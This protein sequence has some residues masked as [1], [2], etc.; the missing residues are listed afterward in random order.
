MGGKRRRAEAV[1]TAVMTPWVGCRDGQTIV[2]AESAEKMETIGAINQLRAWVRAQKR[3][4]L[5]VALVPTM[6]ALHD[7]HRACIETACGVGDVVVVSIFVNPTQF[8]V[9]EDLDKYPVTI[10]RDLDVCRN[11]GV[12]A[13][14][15]PDRAEMYP[16]DQIVWV[17]VGKLTEGLC[18]RARSGHFRGVATVVAKLFNIVTPDAAVF[19]QKDAQQAVVIKE[20]A[21]QLNVPVRVVLTPTVREPDG[22]ALSSRNSYLSPGHRR[23]AA[24]IYQA[25][26]AGKRALTRGARDP[27]EVTGAV[28]A[29]LTDAGIDDIEYVELVD[30]ENLEP[31][32]EVPTGAPSEPGEGTSAGGGATPRGTVLL[33]V[34]VRIGGTRLIDN[35][36]LR[37][38]TAG[39]AVEAMLF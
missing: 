16:V 33:A 4:G 2:A 29:A 1:A 15:L 32:N 35:L 19:G 7:G 24:S 23:Q 13:V 3:R 12:G 9:G 11:L 5:S 36:V 20:M 22:L 10:D 21:G 6:G 8:G 31:L 39:E 27:N 38:D 25:L 34:A 37:F 17:E 18:G 28:R 30:A 14:F 26:L